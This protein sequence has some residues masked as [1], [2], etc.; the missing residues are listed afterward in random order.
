MTSY[1]FISGAAGGL[2]RVFCD[3]C[4]LRGWD[5]FL[6][7]L[8]SAPLEELAR[9]LGNRHGVDVRYLAGDF[10]TA[11]SRDAFFHALEALELRFH[12]LINV[13][14]VEFEAPFRCQSLEQMRLIMN[15]NMNGTVELTSRVLAMRQPDS[16]FRL[17]TVSSLAYPYPMPY[18]AIYS[19]SKRFLY[20]FFTA[21][22]E[23]LRSENV[24]VTLLCPAGMPTRQ[25][26]IDRIEA[27]G[28]IGK[29]TTVS[30]R[31]AVRLSLEAALK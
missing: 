9:D 1:V 14:G 15:V 24:T 31:K 13:A 4:A 2:G 27:Q 29:L 3:E 17:L 7:D 16:R 20:Q 22:R 8:P 11:V 5:L 26:V 23:E 28:R 21:L 30:P 10:L 18:K 12:F 19:S 6:T 25:V